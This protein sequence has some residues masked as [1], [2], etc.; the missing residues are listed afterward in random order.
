MASIQSFLVDYLLIFCGGAFLAISPIIYRANS[1]RAANRYFALQMVI[2]GVWTINYSFSVRAGANATDHLRVGSVIASALPWVLACVQDLLSRGDDRQRPLRRTHLT[3]GSISLGLAAC[4]PWSEFLHEHPDLQHPHYGVLWTGYHLVLCL[5]MAVIAWDAYR[6]SKRVSVRSRDEMLTAVLAAAGTIAVVSGFM[7]LVIGEPRLPPPEY[8]LIVIVY[9]FT[10]AWVIVARGI[11]DARAVMR[12]LFRTGGMVLG[13]AI[14]FL[15]LSLLLRR[16]T[17]L[18]DMVASLLASLASAGI[19]IAI[20]RAFLRRQNALLY[21]SIGGFQSRVNA[22][23]REATSADIAVAMLEKVVAEYTG[24]TRA[25]L[26][27][28]LQQGLYQRG[29]L[30]LRRDAFRWEQIDRVQWVA[31]SNMDLDSLGNDT[32]SALSWVAQEQISLLVQSP[33]SPQHLSVVVALGPRS[34]HQSYTFSE[35]ESLGVMV[36]SCATALT[37][38]AASAQAQ[39]AGQM[40]AIGLISASVIHEVKQPL[41]AL[42]LFFKMLPSRYQDEAFRSEYFTVIP[43]ELARIEETLSQLLRLGRT[44]NFSVSAFDPV[45][46]VEETLTLVQPKASAS[47]VEISSALDHRALRIQGDPIVFKQALLN[48]A[49]NAIE[50]MSRHVNDQRHL[51]VVGRHDGSHY[52]VLVRDTGP[53]IP[54]VI[55]NRLFRPFVT[56]KEDGVGLGLYITR[57]QVV[58][59]GGALS[60]HNHEDGGAVFVLRFP[61]ATSETAPAETTP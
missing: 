2:A 42:R 41:A 36:E 25:L 18:S 13:V 61:L 49:L 44:E 26:L 52:E 27:T 19:G 6:T 24:T 34:D 22:I 39:H 5:V 12:I 53:G 60:A 3:W 45:P 28:E 31:R 4:T 1:L 32:E 59:T 9:A 23:V 33:E 46:L 10:L 54:P 50:A 55:L 48:L 47:F 15:G 29:H 57:D 8:A 51:Q 37:T 11:Y 40:M 43:K 17:P 14:V 20:T 7:V 16:F 30:Y 38:I 56:T 21:R 35:L 58:K